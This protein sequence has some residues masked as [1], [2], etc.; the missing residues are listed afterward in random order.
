MVPFR[1]G[2]FVTI[3]FGDPEALCNALNKKDVFLI[4]VGGGVRVSI[5][6]SSEEKCR[7]LPAI[8]KAAMNELI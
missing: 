4:P 2:F 8:I 6:S 7:R 3:P 5:A 1:A